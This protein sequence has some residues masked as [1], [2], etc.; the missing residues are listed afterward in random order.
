MPRKSLSDKKSPIRLYG[1]VEALLGALS[2]GETHVEILLMPIA[3]RL[4][5]GTGT[6][7]TQVAVLLTGQ[8]ANIVYA[9][10]VL[11]AEAS[12]VGEKGRIIYP[13]KAADDP[14]VTHQLQRLQ[15]ELLTVLTTA[16]QKDSRVS[17]IGCPA[18]LEIPQLRVWP[19]Y[20]LMHFPIVFRDRHWI[21]AEEEHHG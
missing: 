14:Q 11:A 18:A 17:S 2:Q 9:C 6:T 13:Y 8:R 16:L 1:T 19:S 15:D 4:M 20:A 5:L 3:H 12:S 10:F 7:R 21:L